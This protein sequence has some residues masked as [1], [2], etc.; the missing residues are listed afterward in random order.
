MNRFRTALIAGFTA[1]LVT[2]S[3]GQDLEEILTKA[4]EEISAK[5]YGSARQ[6]L[7]TILQYNSAYAPAYF[8]LSKIALIQDDLKGAQD[9]IQ[10]AI[11]NDPRNEEYRAEAEKIAEISSIMSDARRSFDE[12][13][14][15]GAVAR[16]EKVLEDHPAFASAYYGMGMAFAREG[17][18][19]QA[20]EAFRK[21]QAYNPDDAR[22]TTALRK[23]VAD[24]F[25]EANRLLRGR[26][27]ESALEIYKEVVELD[28]TFEKTYYWMA[29]SYRMLGD[30]EAALKT[31]DR[32]IE[33]KPDYTTAYVEKGDILRR[34]GRSEEAEAV[35]RQAL[36]LDPKSDK[37]WVGL[38]AIVRSEKPA[39]AVEA[40]KSALSVNPENGDAAGYLGEIY[41]DQEKWAEARKYLEQAV[42]LKTKDQVV[43]WRLAHV[44]NALGEY[45]KARQMGKRSTDLKKTFEYGWYELGLAEKALGNRVAAIEAFKNASNG[46]DASIRKSSQYELKQL[47]T[48]SR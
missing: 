17:N 6:N 22:Y 42:K 25:N 5:N 39:E 16:Y 30:N 36:S 29:R 2:A 40:F 23:I 19:R 9:N 13:D 46:R 14:Y 4:R 32:A 43:T 31:L 35:Y 26:D 21:A 45:E 12:R 3:L 24:K 18:Q 15:M 7:Q 47:E 20:A 33:I 1:I 38:G 10:A 28:P 41:S 44:Y 11:E 8:E 34:D 37:A 27:W 48:S